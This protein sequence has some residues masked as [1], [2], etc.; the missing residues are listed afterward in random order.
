MVF[1]RRAQQRNPADID[2]LDRLGFRDAGPGDRLPERIEVAG[3]DVDGSDAETRQ[4]GQRV[5]RSPGKNAAVNRRMERLDASAQQFGEAGHILDRRDRQSPLGE[6]ACRPAGGNQLKAK[7]E[8]PPCK[9]VKTGLIENAQNGAHGEVL[10]GVRAR[11]GP[12]GYRWCGGRWPQGD[13]RAREHRRHSPRRRAS[14]G[15]R[16]RPRTTAGACPSR[17]RRRG[18]SASACCMT[19]HAAI[20]CSRMT[21]CMAWRSAPRARPVP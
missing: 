18:G 2:L 14:R 10:N 6:G 4:L 7:I 11:R 9:G 17:A 16:R 15:A 8:Q 12:N 13:A 21:S 19:S 1:R 3:D 5:R 20:D